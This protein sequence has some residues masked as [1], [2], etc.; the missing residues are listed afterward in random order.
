MLGAGLAG[1]EDSDIIHTTWSHYQAHIFYDSAVTIIYM[2]WFLTDRLIARK[3][4]TQT[5]G[6]TCVEEGDQADV[7]GHLFGFL[8]MTLDEIIKGTYDLSYLT[9]IFSTFFCRNPW[10]VI[11]AHLNNYVLHKSA[12]HLYPEDASVFSFQ[13]STIAV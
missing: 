9:I 8:I 10:R 6:E 2:I 1:T 5:S 13:F 3:E 12:N 4:V 7:R 11:H